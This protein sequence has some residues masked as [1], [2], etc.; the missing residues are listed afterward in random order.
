MVGYSYGR[1][2]SS[3]VNGWSMDDDEIFELIDEEAVQEAEEG[4]DYEEQ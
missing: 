1:D 4:R 2:A 3:N